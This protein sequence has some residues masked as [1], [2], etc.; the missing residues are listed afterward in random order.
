M[1]SRSGWLGMLAAVVMAGFWLREHDA[2]V[3]AKA[4]LRVEKRQS[5][6]EVAQL[7][8]QAAQEARA[9][10]EE[11]A[12]AM[13][14][15]KAGREKAMAQEKKLAERLAALEAAEHAAVSRMATLPLGEVER[16]LEARLGAGE[17]VTF[18]S[19]AGSKAN[20]ASELRQAGSN[21]T[22]LGEQASAIAQ[23]VRLNTVTVGRDVCQNPT[24]RS[25][26]IPQA[27]CPQEKLL[28]GR[29]HGGGS[30]EA[31]IGLSAA[32]A[33][34]VDVALAELNACRAERANQAQQL[35]ASGARAAADEAALQRQA[36][37]TAELGRALESE[38]QAG[39]ARQAEAKR[40]LKAARGTFLERLARATEHVALGV[41]LGLVAGVALR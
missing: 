35:K 8:R 31:A 26:I 22:G 38:R 15:L 33:R 6:T 39:R 32:G 2:Q 27:G 5:Q 17:V 41:A 10:Q 34:E 11:Q 24:P 21:S 30:S 23:A 12:Q 4:A 3:R 7:E 28:K 1:A 37:A 25:E 20:V 18:G 29:V 36:A 16:Q 9:A 14:R 13:A 40:E 19:A